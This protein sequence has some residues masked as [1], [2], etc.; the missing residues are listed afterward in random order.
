MTGHEWWE[1]A[2]DVLSLVIAALGSILAYLAIRMGREQTRISREQTEIA[3]RQEA[4]DIEQ[5]KI[6]TEQATITR[7][8]HQILEEQ[9]GR[10]AHLEVNI[11]LAKSATGEPYYDINVRN[12]GNKVARDFYIAI[13][14]PLEFKGA[15]RIRSTHE[16]EYSENDIED[17]GLYAVNSYTMDK[18]IF[19]DG[20]DYVFAEVWIQKP[21]KMADLEFVWKIISEDGKFPAGEDSNRISLPQ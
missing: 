19:A 6:A 11:S 13:A 20:Q 21:D 14:Y 9:L 1:V 17:S 4:L 16:V 18:P 12:S 7:K 3:K 15:F 10:K 5:G 8:Q 2:R